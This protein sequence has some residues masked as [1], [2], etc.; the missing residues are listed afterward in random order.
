MLVWQVPEV[1][2]RV[3]ERGPRSGLAGTPATPG[4]CNYTWLDPSQNIPRLKNGIAP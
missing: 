3:A 1:N 2:I 4:L